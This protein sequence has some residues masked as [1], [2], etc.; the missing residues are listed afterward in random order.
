MNPNRSEFLKLTGAAAFAASAGGALPAFA[1]DLHTV[2]VLAVPTDGVKSTLYAQKAGIFKKHGINADIQPMGSGAA[3]FAAVAGGSADVGSGSLFPVFAAYARGV[4]LRIIAAASIYDTNHADAYLFVKKDSPI[5]TARDLNGKVLGADA[6]KDANSTAVR[7][8]VDENGGDGSSLKAVELKPS[9][10]I[11]AL[12]QGRIDAIVLKSPLIQVANATGAFRTIC[13]PLDAIAPRFVLSCWISSLDFIQKNTPLVNNYIAAL[14]EASRYT[15]AH[16][17][18]TVD[19][20][21]QFT[22]QDPAVVAKGVRSVTAE[23][24]SVADVQRPLDIAVKYGIIDKPF[25]AS[26]LIYR[27]G[28]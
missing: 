3:I 27:P 17:A 7:A 21:A 25:D 19:M 14:A 23:S 28:K 2:R 22:G 4:Q 12:Q 6:V 18:A 1:Q 9:E 26:G 24:I 10:Q 15:N 11:A 13:K 5:R 20:V 16:Q 8:W